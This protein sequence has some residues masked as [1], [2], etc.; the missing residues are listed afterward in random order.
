[1]LQQKLQE[2]SNHKSAKTHAGT[3]FV[4]RDLDL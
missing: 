1:M 2:A 4:I 3:G